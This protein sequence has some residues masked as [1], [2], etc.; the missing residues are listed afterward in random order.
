MNRLSIEVFKTLFAVGWIDG[1][2]RESESYLILAAARAEG[3]DEAQLA[4]LAPYASQPIDFGEIEV[5]SL[6]P[7]ARLYIY[8]VA[9]WIAHTDGRVAPTERHALPAVATLCGISGRGR[10][11][12]DEQVATYPADVEPAVLR[13]AIS[14]AAAEL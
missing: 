2:L 5:G 14:A 3:L 10:V 9:S 6:E 12:M 11:A 7:D 13:A 8:A 4:Q 1:E